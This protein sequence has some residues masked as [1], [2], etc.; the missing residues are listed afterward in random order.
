MVKHI[1]PRGYNKMQHPL[2]HNFSYQGIFDILDTAKDA[3]IITL[4]RGSETTLDPST[5]EVN[6][7]HD[8]F[9][10]DQ[11]PTCI[12][13][14]IIPK[15][16]LTLRASLSQA[17]LLDNEFAKVVIHMMPIYIAFE[18]SLIAKNMNSPAES[19][20]ED[21]LG[22][23]HTA[24][25]YR[26]N[27]NFA[28]KLTTRGSHPLST[29]TATDSA[30][31]WGLTTNAELESVAFNSELMYDAFQYYTNSGMLNKVVGPIKTWTLTR[32]RPAFYH[33]DNFT[34]PAVKRINPYTFCAFMLWSEIPG[35][36][37]YGFASDFDATDKD[38]LF[39]NA[40]IRFNEWNAEFDQTT[41]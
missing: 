32:D 34:N 28:S 33:S 6:P 38:T 36:H 3:T 15:V 14:S 4:F 2:P 41:T 40:D 37:S 12:F 25:S 30:T 13:D 29:I 11:G 31:T 9:A 19:E 16:N 5:I 21:I 22:L 27:P 23:E 35:L 20:V 39:F 24:S 8:N 10:E 26:T 18:D 17:M 1:P 7:R